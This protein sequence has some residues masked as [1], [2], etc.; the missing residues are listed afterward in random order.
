[1]TNIKY[2]DP[3]NKV[4]QDQDIDILKEIQLLR[5]TWSSWETRE[6]KN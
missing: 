5:S 4:C 3:L 2:T 6:Q 1:M